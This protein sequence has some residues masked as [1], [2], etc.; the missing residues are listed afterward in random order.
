MKVQVLGTGLTKFG[1]LWGDSLLSLAQEAGS[2]AI[3]DAG[4]PAREIDLLLVANMLASRV[5]K[6]GHLGAAV[7][8]VLGL[9][10]PALHIEAACASGGVAVR[11]G[12]LAVSSAQAKNVLVVGVEKMTDVGVAEITS[13]LME[14]GDAETEGLAGATFPSLYAMIARA[15]MAEYKASEEDLAHVAVKNHEHASLN[16]LAQYPFPVTVEQVLASAVIADP[17]KLLDCSP[18]T[19]GAAAVVLGKTEDGRRKTKDGKKVFIVG[20][21]QG[22]DTLALAD[23]RD[24]TSLKAT[25]DAAGK[26]YKEAGIESED[27]GLAEVHDC[28]SIAEILAL[29]DLGFAKRGEG[30]KLLRNGD[31]K[32]GGRCPVNASGGLK[33]CGHPVGATGVKQVAEV[34]KQLQGEAGKRQVKGAKI[35]LAHN[36]GGSGASAVVHILRNE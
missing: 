7:A 6:Q 35:G 14:A 34:T 24:L 29:E 36:V 2:Q 18:I 4:V 20:S 16:P 25:R 13:A 30:Y 21:G 5:A 31:L 9:T 17:L 10:C 28:F 23:R 27:L 19:D 12:A 26:A 32:L 22:Q 15:Y 33:A 8:S 1:E 3:E 11:M